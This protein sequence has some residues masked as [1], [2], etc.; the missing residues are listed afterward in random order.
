MRWR[1]RVRRSCLYSQA[2]GQ[3]EAGFQPTVDQALHL[4]NSQKLITLNAKPDTAIGRPLSIA[5]SGLVV[6][7]LYLS[8]L[9]R[10]PTSGESS[11]VSLTLE[12]SGSSAEKS[13]TLNSLRWGLLLSAEFRLNH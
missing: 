7:E 4:M 9:T 5:E 10:R 6:E 3:P 11:A 8:V 1:A 2:P 12:Q 13:A